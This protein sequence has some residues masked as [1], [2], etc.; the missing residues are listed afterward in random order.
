LDNNSSIFEIGSGMVIS[1][2]DK[3]VQGMRIGDKK[4]FSVPPEEAFG[5]RKKDH[6]YYRANTEFTPFTSKCFVFTLST[7][8]VGESIVISSVIPAGPESSL[9]GIQSA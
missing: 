5:Q 6:D 9:G 1:C 3:E 4:K 7:W 8:A 2:L